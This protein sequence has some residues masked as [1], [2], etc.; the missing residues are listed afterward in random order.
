MRTILLTSR[1][2]GPAK[3]SRAR[4]ELLGVNGSTCAMEVVVT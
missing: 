1:H 2:C 4:A 3:P